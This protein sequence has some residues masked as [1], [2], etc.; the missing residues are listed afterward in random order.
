MPDISLPVYR[1]QQNLNILNTLETVKEREREE[2]PL[3][4][5]LYT[6]GFFCLI[7]PDL[8]SLD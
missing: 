7:Q 8:T 4:L 3:R 6:S 1:I 5:T 2:G